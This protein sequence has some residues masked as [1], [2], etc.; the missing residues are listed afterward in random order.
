MRMNYVAGQLLIE[1]PTSL[2]HFQPSC[3]SHEI[4][5][6][7]NRT[8]SGLL[9]INR[10]PDF[11]AGLFDLIISNLRLHKMVGPELY[12]EI[13]RIDPKRECMFLPAFEVNHEDLKRVVIL[14]PFFKLPIPI[15]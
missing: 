13:K 8:L 10:L 7:C 14:C 2:Q 4:N 15:S 5:R 11:K 3:T 6:L 1:L 12:R 9:Y